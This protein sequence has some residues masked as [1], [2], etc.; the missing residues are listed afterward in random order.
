[1]TVDIYM[2]TF[3][4]KESMMTEFYIKKTLL[5]YFYHYWNDD[6]WSVVIIDTDLSPQSKPGHRELYS[7]ITES[8]WLLMF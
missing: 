4:M 5:K 7:R 6:W 8:Q 3:I 2:A 1:M